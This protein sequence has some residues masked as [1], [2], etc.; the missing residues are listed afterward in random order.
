MEKHVE[1]VPKLNDYKQSYILA[2]RLQLNPRIIGKI[3][4]TVLVALN[5]NDEHAGSH[6]KKLNIGLQLKNRKQSTTISDYVLN[7]DNNWVYSSKAFALVEEYL[8]KFPFVFQVLNEDKEFG[9]YQASDFAENNN[10]ANGYLNQLVEWLHSLPHFKLKP[11]SLDMKYLTVA[12]MDEVTNEID[13]AVSYK[14]H[15]ILFVFLLSDF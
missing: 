4:G 2:T 1:S 13:R 9:V 12:A 8:Q 6:Q 10:D 3:T 14:I 7:V 15:L 5:E 11:E